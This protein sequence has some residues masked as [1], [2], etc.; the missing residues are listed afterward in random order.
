MKNLQQQLSCNRP[1]IFE[2]AWYIPV[3]TG[4][5]SRGLLGLYW[6]E[7]ETGSGGKRSAT[8]TAAP[9]KT[10]L[11]LGR[12][13]GIALDNLDALDALLRQNTL[14]DCIVD[15]VNEPLILVESDFAPV[16]ANASARSLA[17]RLVPAHTASLSSG[18]SHVRE[19]AQSLA[20][21]RALLRL[22]EIREAPP[23]RGQSVGKDVVLPDGSSFAVRVHS[24][25]DSGA[26]VFRA[27]IHLRETTEEKRMAAQM[28]QADKLA[29]VGQLAAGLAH[30]I[31]NP[32]GVIRC[33]AELMNNATLD[34]QGR[35]DLDIIM[36]HVDQAQAILHD[37]LNFSRAREAHPTLCDINDHMRKVCDFFRP[38]AR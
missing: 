35:A 7:Q 8:A 5:Q 37:M 22:M 1:S 18:A 11:A 21:I 27:V 32:L 29:A 17:Q 4:G 25:A 34:E 33:Y 3:Q 20:G 15:G 28:R 6:H 2:H 13:L 23:S 30:E 10:Y 12:Q 19:H 26:R 31:N 38:Q 9:D 24:L 36:R 14:L 16:L